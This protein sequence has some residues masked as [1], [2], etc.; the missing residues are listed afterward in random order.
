[1]GVGEF[2]KSRT[3]CPFNAL[4]FNAFYRVDRI[5]TVFELLKS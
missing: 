1:M 2:S 3:V 5:G 4:I